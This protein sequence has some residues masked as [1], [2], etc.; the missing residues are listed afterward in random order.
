MYMGSNGAICVYVRCITSDLRMSSKMYFK[1][2]YWSIKDMVS[3]WGIVSLHRDKG[4][5]SR[6]DA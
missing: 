6:H 2:L 4:R 5:P 1:G 3:K